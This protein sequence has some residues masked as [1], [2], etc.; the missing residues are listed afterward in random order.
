MGP[1]R[2]SLYPSKIPPRPTH[3]SRP[4]SPARARHSRQT[5]PAPNGEVPVTVSGSTVTINLALDSARPDGGDGLQRDG[6]RAPSPEPGGRQGGPD[7]RPG[8]D[9]R[10]GRDG[11]D[12]GLRI[13][14]KPITRSGGKPITCSGA[15]RSPVPTQTDH[16]SERSDAGRNHESRVSVRV[17]GRLR[18]RIESPFRSSLYALCTRRSRIASASVGSP[19]MSCHL[20]TGTWLVTTVERTPW[21]SSRTSSRSW[22]FSAL[23]GAAPSHPSPAPRSWRAIRA[24]SG[25]ARRRAQ[26]PGRSAAGTRGHTTRCVRCGRRCGRARILSSFFRC[27]SGRRSGP[28]RLPQLCGAPHSAEHFSEHFSVGGAAANVRQWQGVSPRR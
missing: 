15:N 5:V 2:W 27:R 23:N 4:T 1:G 13:P 14:V 10:A 9:Q 17:D 28:L 8:G 16:L 26:W 6:G 11:P 3:G 22:R 19:T 25:S 21:R 20:S 18:F 24:A 12:G 7:Q